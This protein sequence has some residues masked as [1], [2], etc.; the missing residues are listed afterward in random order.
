MVKDLDCFD[1]IGESRRNVVP[2]RKVSH[3]HCIEVAPIDVATS[4]ISKERQLKTYPM[5]EPQR[6]GTRVLKESCSLADKAIAE[7]GGD[8]EALAHVVETVRLLAARSLNRPR[9]K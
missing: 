9:P 1:E 6:S 3:G 7:L 4:A 5:P 8:E 2:H